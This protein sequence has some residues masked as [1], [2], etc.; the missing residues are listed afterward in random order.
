M[1]NLYPSF[2]L[3]MLVINSAKLQCFEYKHTEQH[4]T[5]YKFALYIKRPRSDE[6]RIGLGILVYS[7]LVSLDNWILRYCRRPVAFFLNWY[8]TM[9]IFKPIWTNS[10]SL[11]L[12]CWITYFRWAKVG[13]RT[14][15]HC[16]TAL[17]ALNDPTGCLYG[18]III[19]PT[20]RRPDTYNMSLLER[21]PWFNIA[22]KTKHK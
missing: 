16:L 20:L 12:K 10:K 2:V 11:S 14:L 21:Q 7:Q 19:G 4:Y 3:W 17:W 1:H 13:S 15:D 18:R 5:I 6:E 9:T 22:W 8:K